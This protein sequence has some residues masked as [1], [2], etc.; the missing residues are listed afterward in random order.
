MAGR[1]HERVPADH[2]NAVFLNGLAD[3][4]D[5]VRASIE[6][7]DL[8]LLFA[9]GSMAEGACAEC[10]ALVRNEE[11]HYMWHREIEARLGRVEES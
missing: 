3:A 2:V 9:P 11:V 4:E 5:R 1:M 7:G 10:G 8:S 6:Q